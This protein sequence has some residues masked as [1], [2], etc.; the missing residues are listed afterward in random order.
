MLPPTSSCLH[1]YL[2]LLLSH[3]CLHVKSMFG[4]PTRYA[5]VRLLFAYRV[6][7]TIVFPFLGTFLQNKQC[8][9]NILIDIVKFCEYNANV[10]TR[11]DRVSDLN[12]CFI[13]ISITDIMPINNPA[14][15]EISPQLV[16]VKI[17]CTVCAK[18]NTIRELNSGIYRQEFN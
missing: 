3:Y 6:S 18:E 9:H 11:S 17:V 16:Y 13:Q 7:R 10:S 5:S 15:Q 12:C 4:I 2:I 1:C 8:R 14:T